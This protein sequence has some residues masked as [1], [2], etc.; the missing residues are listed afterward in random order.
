MKSR[1]ERAEELSLARTNKTIS[2]GK[3]SK[4]S[5][6][7]SLLNLNLFLPTISPASLSSLLSIITHTSCTYSLLVIKAVSRVVPQRDT[8]IFFSFL[9]FFLP[10][11]RRRERDPLYIHTVF[12]CICAYIHISKRCWSRHEPKK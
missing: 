9:S 2:S 10:T 11:Q 1:G 7:S 8:K 6:P 5:E 4:R 12:V 3:L